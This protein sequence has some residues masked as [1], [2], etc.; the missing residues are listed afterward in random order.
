M[1]GK[2]IAIS[3]YLCGNKFSFATSSAQILTCQDKNDEALLQKRQPK[4]QRPKVLKLSGVLAGQIFVCVRG[5]MR[6]AL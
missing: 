1:E 5:L 6:E 2:S 4:V 3:K